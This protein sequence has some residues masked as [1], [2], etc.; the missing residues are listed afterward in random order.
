M[1]DHAAGEARP[2]SV[3]SKPVG[4]R[5]NIDCAYCYYLDKEKLYPDERRFRMSE[6]VLEAY[7]RQMIGA[8]RR[9]GQKAVQFSWQGGEPTLRGL[10]F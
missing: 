5:C 6:T 7:V 9:S 8:A 2:F 10:A 4:P 3:M 1:S